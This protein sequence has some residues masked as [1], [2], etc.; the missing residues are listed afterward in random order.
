[1]SKSCLVSKLK[2]L[3]QKLS[4]YLGSHAQA[5]Q[6]IRW[7]L[8]YITAKRAPFKALSEQTL[9]TL[10]QLLTDRI[11]RHKPLQYIIGSVPFLDM[12]LTVRPP[13]LIPRPETEEIVERL[14]TSLAHMKH[15]SLSF[16]D[17]CTGS[18]C[19]ALALAQA[20]PD[21]TVIG[22][23]ICHK[24]L[25]L[26]RENAA[27]VGLTNVSFIHSNLFEKLSGKTFDLIISN[28]PYLAPQE[29]S[30]LDQGVTNWEDKQALVAQKN[31]GLFFYHAI[32]EQAVHFLKS[33]DLPCNLIFEIGHTQKKAVSDIL[34]LH[35]FK[36]ITAHNDL[37][38]KSRC[39][40]GRLLL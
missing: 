17:M 29:W 39:V 5:E 26:A 34:A 35:S 37:S 6:E 22:V 4:S 8:E 30:D 25:A 15:R 19:I 28:P 14:I 20:F 3:T 18:G 33:S 36:D 7:L 1:M 12:T 24:A 23:D 40:S 11:E 9:A 21:S 16:L 32:T 27:N 31:D 10:A 2:H 13:T 38:N